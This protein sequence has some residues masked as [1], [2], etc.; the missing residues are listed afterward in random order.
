M[1]PLFLRPFFFLSHRRRLWHTHSTPWQKIGPLEL[2]AVPCQF[3]PPPPSSPVTYRHTP[4]VNAASGLCAVN[5]MRIS[6]YHRPRESI[7]FY[8]GRTVVDDLSRF[9]FCPL[10]GQELI[11]MQINV[12]SFHNRLF[13]LLMTSVFFKKRNWNYRL[14]FPISFCCIWC[15]SLAACRDWVFLVQLVLIWPIFTNHAPCTRKDV[16]SLFFTLVIY[17]DFWFFSKI[18]EDFDF[19][20]LGA[21]INGVKCDLKTKTTKNEMRIRS[22]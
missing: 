20:G 14:F 16:V 3:P 12:E 8:I 17:F 9:F 6:S 18:I 19:N 4:S 5:L 10:D 21:S 11:N 22:R 13:F 15:V 2:L 1:L 7:Q